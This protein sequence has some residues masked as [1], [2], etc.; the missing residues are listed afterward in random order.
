MYIF[1]TT[2]S[3]SDCRSLQANEISNSLSICLVI[4]GRAL[5]SR[6]EACRVPIVA[7]TD[8]YVSLL[9]C[10]GSLRLP[11]V[12]PVESATE[13]PGGG[14]GLLRSLIDYLETKTAE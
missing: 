11:D 9:L 1:S 7:R 6:S 13:R 3:K 8:S 5:R 4:G 14:S 12:P 10:V 2:V